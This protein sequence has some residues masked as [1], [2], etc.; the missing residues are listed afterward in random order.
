M[1][2]TRLD[3]RQENTM[4][5][6]TALSIFAALTLAGLPACDDKKETK[7]EEKKTDTKDGK[8]T[9]ETKTETKTEDKK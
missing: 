7:T 5:L 1:P 4:K 2:L 3:P 6:T 9:T 8:T